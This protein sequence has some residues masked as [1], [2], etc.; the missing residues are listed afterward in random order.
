MLNTCD[1]CELKLSLKKCESLALHSDM[2]TLLCRHKWLTAEQRASA[3][4]VT[5][6]HVYPESPVLPDTQTCS[7]PPATARGSG[8]LGV[9]E[10]PAPPALFLL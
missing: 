5:G 10:G 6:R 8:D 7:V 1:V 9:T 3:W 2:G 4:D